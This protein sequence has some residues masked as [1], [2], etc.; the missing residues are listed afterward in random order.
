MYRERSWSRDD[1]AQPQS[2]VLGVDGQLLA[3]HVRGV[4]RDL[5]Q[6]PLHDRVEPPGADVLG[7]R[8]HLHGDLGDRLHRLRQKTQ[9][10]LLRPQQLHVLPDQGVLGLGQDA[11]EIL[12][13]QGL[14]LDPD[15]KAPLQLGDQVGGLG[16]VEGAGGDEQDVVGADHA[17]LGGHRGAL[18]D[19]QEVPLDPLAGHVGAVAAFAA[20]DL[21]QLVQEDDAGVLD[22]PDGLARPPLPCRPASGPLP[23]PG[24][25]GPRA[26][27]T[28]RRLVRLGRTFDSMSL[29]WMPISSM[30][31]PEK[32]STIGIDCC[33]VS[34]STIRSSSLPARSWARS[35]SSVA[36]RE[37]SGATCSSEPLLK[38]SRAPARQQEIE[39]PI[40]GEPLGLLLHLGHQLGLD[41][42]DAQL[43]E[44]AD[45]R[46]DVAADVAD[47]GVLRGL[48][49]D[50]GRLGELGQ[51]AGDLGL[52]RRRW[53]R[54]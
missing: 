28:R 6:Q 1:L 37:A 10:H 15:G 2:H 46:L 4:E 38:G 53:G 9:R 25:A 21:V 44:V 26:T 41:H 54:S 24:A 11:D 43:G 12:A 14:Q 20:G 52:A 27:R 8:V 23:G 40:L 16:D 7:A 5:V 29:S 39:Q 47:L 18:D 30:P 48:D 49:L 17:V 31:W 22:P 3:R 13:R 45:H 35:F 50:E 33:C 51:P 34:S 32:T 42:G 36:S 19:R